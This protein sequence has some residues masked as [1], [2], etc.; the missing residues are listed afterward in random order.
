MAASRSASAKTMLG[1]LPPSSRATRFTVG[2]AAAMI[3]RPVTMPPVKETRSTSGASVSIGPTRSPAPVTRLA[4]PVGRP[5]SV[6]A[7]TSH[8]AVDGVSSL[9]LS[10]KVFPAA[11]AGATFQAV[12]SSG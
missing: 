3:R 8:I 1:F 10:T 6:S 2:A 7:S 4:T 12:C 5:T 9:G 11:S